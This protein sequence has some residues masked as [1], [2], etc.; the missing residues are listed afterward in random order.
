MVVVIPAVVAAEYHRVT[1]RLVVAAAV[2]SEE[3]VDSEAAVDSEVVDLL[4]VTEHP[5][6]V[7][8]VADIPAE[9]VPHL[10]TTERPRLQ[11]TELPAPVVVAV[12]VVSEVV[13]AV[14]RLPAAMERLALHL[15]VT[16]P[17]LGLPRA[18]TERRP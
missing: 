11:V 7:E 10:P 13:S 17:R 4:R 12:A 1:A 18:A 6:P 5:L 3:V 2:D 9:V 14:E 8:V 16:V 15:R